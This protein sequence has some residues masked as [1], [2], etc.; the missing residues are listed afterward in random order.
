MSE[1]ASPFMSRRPARCQA[2]PQS[3]PRLTRFMAV[4]G[5]TEA[6]SGIWA[7]LDSTRR[8]HG[9]ARRHRSSPRSRHEDLNQRSRAMTTFVDRFR[10][11]YNFDAE[12]VTSGIFQGDILWRN[13]SGENVLWLMN[14]KGPA[15]LRRCRPSPRT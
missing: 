7:S 9:N 6:P 14:N 4:G 13:H 3:M 15:A 11:D 2:G 10:S 12:M 1:R 8:L 5:W